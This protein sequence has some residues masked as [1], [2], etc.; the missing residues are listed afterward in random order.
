MKELGVSQGRAGRHSGEHQLQAMLRPEE[1][2]KGGKAVVRVGRLAHG[3]SVE[4]RAKERQIAASRLVSG[5]ALIRLRRMQPRLIR[6]KQLL[7]SN[8]SE[9]PET[10]AERARRRADEARAAVAKVWPELLDT[11]AIDTTL[12]DLALS[13]TVMERFDDGYRFEL[14]KEWLRGLPRGKPPKDR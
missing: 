7:V 5:V 9:I 3:R 6:T 1:L 2:L 10:D 12:H 11:T 13:K 4:G 8:A 14:G